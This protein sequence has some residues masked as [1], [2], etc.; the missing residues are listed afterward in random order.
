M[1]LRLDART[2]SPVLSS[3]CPRVRCVSRK[4]ALSLAGG[5]TTP[6]R[7]PS[8]HREQQKDDAAP[9]GWGGSAAGLVRALA[10]WESASRLASGR[11]D[12]CANA[13]KGHSKM[14]TTTQRRQAVGG[15]DACGV[16]GRGVF[17]E[18]CSL[19]HQRAGVRQAGDRGIDRRPVIDVALHR[20]VCACD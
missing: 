7:K 10:R 3:S 18:L 15:P 1:Y 9:C 14:I 20:R 11:V 16:S 17:W 2:A 6:P 4:T 8:P 12:D 13:A 5:G 19:A